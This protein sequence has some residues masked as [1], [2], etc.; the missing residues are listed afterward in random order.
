[1]AASESVNPVDLLREQIEGASPDVLQAMIKTFA[2]AVMSAE[3]DAICSHSSSTGFTLSEAAIAHH[4]PS[5][6][7]AVSKDRA[8]AVSYL[9]NT[10]ITG[11]SYTTPVDATVRR[12]SRS[13]YAHFRTNQTRYGT[14]VPCSDRTGASARRRITQESR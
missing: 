9:R 3:A 4:S 2:Q 6:G 13:G 5:L 8:V 1:M 12:G 10:P 11:K 14:G 7:L